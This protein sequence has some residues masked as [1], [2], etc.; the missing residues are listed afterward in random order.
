MG[1]GRVYEPLT[2]RRFEGRAWLGAVML[3][4][5][6]PPG[7]SLSLPSPVGGALLRGGCCLCPGPLR[8]AQGRG[9]AWPSFG[10]VEAQPAA[11]V[12]GWGFSAT[13]PA[14]SLGSC[15]ESLTVHPGICAQVANAGRGLGGVSN[16]VAG[17][18][19]VEVDVDGDCRAGEDQE[20]ED[21]QD[22]SDAHELKRW[23][24]ARAVSGQPGAFRLKSMRQETCQ[25]D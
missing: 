4:P 18:P 15:Q 14:F 24:E 19:G 8:L 11:W 21:G 6:V 10:W 23:R 9:H 25:L 20:P 1:R 2:Q 3:P 13:S 22:V 12:G 7:L 5:G 17:G 16:G